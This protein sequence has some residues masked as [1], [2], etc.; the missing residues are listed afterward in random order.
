MMI[1]KLLG[2]LPEHQMEEFLKT[3]SC[4]QEDL[5][6]DKREYVNISKNI[7]YLLRHAAGI[8]RSGGWVKFDH[9]M[10]KMHLEHIVGYSTML[11]L[12]LLN[13]KSRFRLN[14]DFIELGEG[15]TR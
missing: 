9:L 12:I 7:A 4:V 5:K 10:D 13:S 2:E 15:E 6:W 11:A 14:I 8:Q 3:A 1:R